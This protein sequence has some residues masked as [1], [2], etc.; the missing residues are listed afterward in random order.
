M[1]Q[2]VLVTCSGPDRVGVVVALT[3]RL[4]DLGIDLGDTTFAVLGTAFEFSSVA[5]APA[6][7]SHAEIDA[8]LSDLPELEGCKLSVSDFAYDPHHAETGR[9]THRIRV[10]GGD[11]LGLVA[12]LT[13]AFVEF[14]ANIV[15]LNSQRHLV[16]DEQQ[17]TTSFDV[18]LKP[19][20]AA[21]CL[22]AVANTAEQLHHE[23]RWEAL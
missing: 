5:S 10:T 14:D 11:Q 7:L 3:G 20:R 8:A 15:R 17:Y 16:G 13:E 23:C 9:R 21:A 19:D 6:A 18:A 22:A 4:F 2:T 1:T 12:R